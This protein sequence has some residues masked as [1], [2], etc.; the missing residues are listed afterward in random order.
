MCTSQTMDHFLVPMISETEWKQL[1][2]ENPVHSGDT[3]KL[4]IYLVYLF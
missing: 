1:R 2:N 4:T 3:K